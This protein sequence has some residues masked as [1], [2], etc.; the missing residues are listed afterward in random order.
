MP[1]DEFETSMRNIVATTSSQLV[2]D[3]LTSFT[4]LTNELRSLRSTARVQTTFLS[5]P[6]IAT[7]LTKPDVRFR[8]LKSMSNPMSVF[9]I[10]PSRLITRGSTYNRLP[11]L[12]LHGALDA[13]MATPKEHNRP[14]NF[15]MDEFASLGPMPIV[16][17][18]M[19]EGA[20]Y[21]IQQT[22]IVQSLAALKDIYKTNF[23]TF[24]ANSACQQWFTP[25]DWGTAEYLSKML[26]HYTTTS[27]SV[28]AKGEASTSETGRP[29]LRPEE[30][31]ALP[32]HTQIVLLRN[33][34]N[35]LMLYRS[36][37]F[38][39]SWGLQGKYDPNPYHVE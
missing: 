9:T 23:E 20:G 18:M 24:I 14:V 28:N 1:D 27:Q 7:A 32:E 6:Q 30:L 21:G 34:P 31:M 17:R 33:C 4:N 37:Y 39:A 12:A 15:L 19:S 10:L 5:D 2:R 3:R 36:P 25:R 16:E 29:L 22:I 11:R 13:M 26:G 35:P 8:Q 38:K